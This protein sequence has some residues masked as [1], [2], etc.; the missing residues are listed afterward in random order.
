MSRH[1]HADLICAW[2]NGAEIERKS[3]GKWIT[4]EWTDI[5]HHDFEYRIKP[6]PKPDVVCYYKPMRNDRTRLPGDDLKLTF[7][8]ETGKLKS[9]EVIG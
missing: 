3:C 4:H 9:A 2:A 5:W 8:G 6:Q 7:D 1:K